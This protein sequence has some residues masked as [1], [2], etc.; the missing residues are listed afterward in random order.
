MSFTPENLPWLEPYW[1]H[2]L[3]CLSVGRVPQ[4]LLIGGNAGMGKMPLA[5]ALAQRLL[6]RQP[7]DFACGQCASCHL[8]DAQTHPDFLVVEPAEPGKAIAIDAIRGLIGTLSLKPQ[9]CGYRVVILAAAHHM[10]S[11]AANSLLKTLEEPDEHTIMLLLTESPSSLPATI[12]SRCQRMSITIRDQGRMID[13]LEDQGVAG[14]AEILL[15]MAQGAP[16]RA[17][18]LAQEGLIERRRDFF[19]DWLNVG[20][21][22]AEPVLVA[23]DWAKFSGDTLMEWLISW[24][25][26]LIRLCAAPNCRT[27]NNPDL[28]QSLQAMA[29]QLK[30]KDI[31]GFLDLL[32]T[33]RR[34]LTGQINRQLAM[35]ELLIHWSQVPKIPQ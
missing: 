34:G 5:R 32:N 21:R 24:V 10:N 33:T 35:E 8:F 4:V 19:A 9:Y 15:A 2:L 1:R 14:Q 11:A 20:C 27:L 31:F 25:M 7:G 26:D 18:T 16:L 22:G 6:C 13:W 12:L 23:D 17:L 29:K 28:T 30:L 3:A